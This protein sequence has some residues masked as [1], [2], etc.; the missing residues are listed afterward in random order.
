MATQFDDLHI[1]ST[2]KPA[3]LRIT[4]MRFA[5]VA[6]AP[7]R[8]VLVRIDTN[9]GITGYGEIRDMATRVYGE[10]LKSRIIGENPCNIDRIFNR[11]KQFGGH[12]RLGGG[13]SGIEIALWDIVGKAYGI[14]VYQMLGGKYVD[15]ARCYCDTDA[16]GKNTGE[17]MG[18]A[19]KAR[20]DYG[21]T[22]LKMDLSPRMFGDE[23]GTLCQ[24]LG[25]GK[26]I[27]SYREMR[28]M[29]DPYEK[30]FWRNYNQDE[31]NKPNS[32]FA[33]S[34]TPKG[35]ELMEQ[36]VK[37]VRDIIGYEIPLAIDHLGK[38]SVQSAI[39]EGRM[40]EKYN[41]LWMEDTIPW[42]YPDQLAEVA[43][44]CATAQCT[45]EDIYTA[46]AFRPLLDKG[47]ISILH[48]DMLTVGGITEARATGRLA[49]EYGLPIVMHMAA[50]PVACLATASVG[51][52]M[53]NF[54][55]M[56]FHSF[57][58]P[59][60]NDMVEIGPKNVMDHGWV[61]PVDAPGFGIEKLN[62][63]VLREHAFSDY[64]EP[65]IPTDKWDLLECHDGLWA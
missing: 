9:Q 5:D 37:E 51:V 7:Y 39:M 24:P 18:K 36:Y 35:M 46:E 22:M 8:C 50:S 47:A 53:R 43:H 52:T 38:I 12:G 16:N 30:K 59:W 20:M 14:P 31:H 26:G 54:L 40:L 60:W 42:R 57:D 41:I 3:D 45:G 13:V 21:F 49:D 17:N 6:N 44:N 33:Q 4:D 56:E 48:P 62:D 25:Y 15:S 29:T 61:T 1:K 55:G 34:I 19:L 58:V 23:P 63:E 64:P 27:P 10:L 11:L 2:G 28:E 65:W 32:Y